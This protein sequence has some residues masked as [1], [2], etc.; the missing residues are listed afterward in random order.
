M[1]RAGSGL[2]AIIPLELVDTQSDE[3]WLMIPTPVFL[4]IACRASD[5]VVALTRPSVNP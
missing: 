1:H 4:P 2:T 5:L 3:L